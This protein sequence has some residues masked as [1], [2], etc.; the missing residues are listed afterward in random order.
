MYTNPSKPVLDAYWFPGRV[1]DV[2]T[3]VQSP[4]WL[5]HDY[6]CFQYLICVCVEICV[7]IK[8]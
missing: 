7:Y 2:H 4:E 3:E 1:E 6:S 8:V 5:G